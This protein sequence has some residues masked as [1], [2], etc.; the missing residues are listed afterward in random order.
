MRLIRKS[1]LARHLGKWAPY[2]NPLSRKVKTPHQQIAIRTGP[3][4]ESELTCEVIAGQAGDR[5][6]L[7][8]L[9]D[10]GPLGVQEVASAINGPDVKCK[11]ESSPPMST[12]TSTMPTPIVKTATAAEEASVIDILVLAFSADPP[13]RWVWPDPQQYLKTFQHFA[14]A[15]GGQRV[16]TWKRLLR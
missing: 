7:R 1:R 13:S 6:Q 4:H 14:K 8:G 16:C 9:Y 15:F 5:F 12:I 11:Q 3:K 10:P 2:M